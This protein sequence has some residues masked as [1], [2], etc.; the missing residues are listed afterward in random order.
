[1]TVLLWILAVIGAIAV[2]YFLLVFAFS[3]VAF[4]VARKMEAEEDQFYPA[5]E[6]GVTHHIFSGSRDEDIEVDSR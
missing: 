6:P 5:F 1:M 3:L 2:L 4:G